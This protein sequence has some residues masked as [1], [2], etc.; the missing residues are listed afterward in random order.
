V[1]ELT[2]AED[3]TIL[4]AT[5]TFLQSYTRKCA[6]ENFRSLK[7][8]VVGAEKLK[9]RIAGAFKEKFGILPLEGYGCTEL[10]PV[11]LINTPNFQDSE[12]T[13]IGNKPGTAGHPIPA[14]AVKIVDPD[15][16]QNLGA[17]K[18][19]LLLIKGPNV[20]KGYLDDEA[21]TKEVI[22]DGWYITGDIAKID[23]DGFVTITDRLSRFSKIGGEMVPHIRI[24][25]EI[26]AA[27]GEIDSICAVTG[28]P[29]ERKGEQ[30]VVLHTKDFDVEKLVSML[31]D[32]GLHNLWIP[33]PNRFYRIDTLPVLGS[34]KLDLKLVSRIAKERVGEEGE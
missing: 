8:V 9:E 33:K 19:G 17:D 29:D 2:Q 15:S 7:Y 4:L 26:H 23:E 27:L 32:R 25:E 34:G 24:E 20:M 6:P 18:E 12:V 11:A 1:G 16:L 10:S 13:Q 28:V 31:S 22:R 14:V 3:A 30:L 5:P 21:L